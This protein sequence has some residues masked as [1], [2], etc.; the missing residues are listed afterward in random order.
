MSHLVTLLSA[1][2]FFA[3]ACDE[4]PTPT[5]DRPLPSPP[6]TAGAVAPMPAPH[7]VPMSQLRPRPERLELGMTTMGKGPVDQYEIELDMK[8]WTL[9]GTATWDE[10]RYELPDP[11]PLSSA[12]QKALEPALDAME[13]VTDSPAVCDEKND[14]PTIS[15]GTSTS[16]TIDGKTYSGDDKACEYVDYPP[17]ADPHDAVGRAFR[18]LASGSTTSTPPTRARDPNTR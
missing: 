15:C 13:I 18:A 6:S 9:E 10:K 16:I 2:A 4:P 12:Q 17:D 1:A 8:R 5:P 3:I 14:D 7:R 11:T